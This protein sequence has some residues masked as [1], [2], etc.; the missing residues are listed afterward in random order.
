M[1]ASAVI[2]IF[3]I[4]ITGEAPRSLPV[5]NASNTGG[6]P[7]HLS[8]SKL[9]IRHSSQAIWHDKQVMLHELI[10]LSFETTHYGGHQ[11][12]VLTKEVKNHD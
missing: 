3:L 12:E 9:L 5:F 6:L 2:F 8:R 10:V 4:V 1:T 7:Y 11:K